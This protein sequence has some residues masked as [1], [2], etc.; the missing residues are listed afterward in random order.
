MEVTVVVLGQ[1]GVGNT[2]FISNC[3]VCT[4]IQPAV[5]CLCR[6]F[7]P[8]GWLLVLYYV[9]R[10][11]TLHTDGASGRCDDQLKQNGGIVWMGRPSSDCKCLVVR[12]ETYIHIPPLPSPLLP[13]PQVNNPTQLIPATIVI[14]LFDLTNEESFHRLNESLELAQRISPTALRAVVGTKADLQEQRQV[15]SLDAVV[16]WHRT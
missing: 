8:A 12:H 10:V 6:T 2:T 1:K 16:R 9:R 5:S 4:D 14:A 15:S 13:S 7:K 11:P 3:L